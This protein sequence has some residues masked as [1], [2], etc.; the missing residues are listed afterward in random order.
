MPIESVGL[1]SY[2]LFEAGLLIEGAAVLT[3]L[4][5]R[6]REQDWQQFRGEDVAEGPG[7]QVALTLGRRDRGENVKTGAKRYSHGR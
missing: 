2:Y 6:L 7:G 3:Q 4:G 1:I 5:G